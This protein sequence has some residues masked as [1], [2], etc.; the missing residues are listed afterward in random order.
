MVVSGGEAFLRPALLQDLAER[1][2]LVGCRTVALSG[3]FWARSHR[4]PP[5]I[6]RAIDPLAH[7]SVSLDVFHEREVRREDVYR[8]LETL[9][10]DGKEVS[11][12]LTGLDPWDPYLAERSD[13]IRRVFEG[14]VPILVNAV[15]YVGRARGWLAK[16]DERPVETAE[17]EP[18]TLAAWPVVAFDG[19]IVG[20]GNDGVVDGP[21]PPAPAAR[22]PATD[23]WPEVRGRYLASPMLRAIRT[24]GPLYVAAD[25]HGAGA[26]RHTATARPAR[27]SRPRPGSRNALLP[28]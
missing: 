2:S 9:V 6:R 16:R 1:A 18:C 13:E 4:I 7:F 12:H 26:V 3:M 5:A 19:T 14:R 8:V 21:T 10:A 11:V 23:D 20:C 15:N 25:R 24:F 17:A 28:R 22:P 27:S